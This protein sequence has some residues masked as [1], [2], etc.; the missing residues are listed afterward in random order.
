MKI[1]AVDRLCIIENGIEVDGPHI[2]SLGGES[3]NR[4]AR[5][6][7]P[8]TIILNCFGTRVSRVALR[9]AFV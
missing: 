4:S 3:T 5:I 9:M 7:V 6:P 1:D 8:Q 2:V